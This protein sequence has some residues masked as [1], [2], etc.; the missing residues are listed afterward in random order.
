MN[1]R[2]LL[3]RSTD[4]VSL[5][6]LE[7][8]DADR[9]AEGTTDPDVRRFAHLPE[10]QY[11]PRRV[12]ELIDSTLEQGITAGA[13]A[14]LAIADTRT[15]QFLGSLVVYDVTP[16]SA[17]VGFWLLP[18]GRGRG[19]AGAALRLAKGLARDAGLHRLRARTM[20]DNTASRGVLERAG[21]TPEGPPSVDT[22]PSG[23]TATMQ[24]FTLDVRG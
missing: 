11:T 2:G 7:Y 9:Y 14:V 1:F 21:F 10:A 12:R 18:D 16:T 5:R 17:E 6:E 19:A 20:V 22:A 15:E 13:L 23:E 3:P 24:D 8:G 4:T